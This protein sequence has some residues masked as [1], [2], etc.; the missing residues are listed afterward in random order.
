MS[1]GQKIGAG[2]EIDVSHSE[3]PTIVGDSAT[4]T[5]QDSGDAVSAIEARLDDVAL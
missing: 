4:P 2:A 1:L 5:N 3:C